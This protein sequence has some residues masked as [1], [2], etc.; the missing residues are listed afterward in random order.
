MFKTKEKCDGYIIE[1]Y[2]VETMR[3]FFGYPPILFYS[4]LVDKELREIINLKAKTFSKKIS[5]R[6]CIS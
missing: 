1:Y 3:F 2:I 4:N 5:G 6:N